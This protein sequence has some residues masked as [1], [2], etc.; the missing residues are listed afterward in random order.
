M[1]VGCGGANPG[2]CAPCQG[3]SFFAAPFCRNCFTCFPLDR[4]RHGCGGQQQ[5]VCVEC[6][7]GRYEDVSEACLECAQCTEPTAMELVE[8]LQVTGAW[9]RIACGGKAAGRCVRMAA[10]LELQDVASCPSS[11]DAEALCEGSKISARWTIQG[12]SSR[13]IDATYGDCTVT[14]GL[15]LSGFFR[16]KLMQ[17]QVDAFDGVELHSWE[18]SSVQ[19][20]STSRVWMSPM[21][22]W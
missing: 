20:L 5:G 17:R 3:G 2:Y 6:S 19:S 11:V 4:I 12:L 9:A 1:R 16:V 14:T 18:I 10:G 15:C 7:K 22:W 13:E 8:G 21:Q